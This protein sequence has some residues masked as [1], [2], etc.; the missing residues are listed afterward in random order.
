ML[1]TEVF[2]YFNSLK[3]HQ[4]AIIFEVLHAE[5]NLLWAIALVLSKTKYFNYPCMY[6]ISFSEKEK[7]KNINKKSSTGLNS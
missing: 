1:T 4:M 3:C 7:S 6:F 2:Q 5:L